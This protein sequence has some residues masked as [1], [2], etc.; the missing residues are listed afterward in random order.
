M[1]PKQIT[2]EERKAILDL[3]RHLGQRPEYWRGDLDDVYRSLKYETQI[4]GVSQD[5]K[6]SFTPQL[7]SIKNSEGLPTS[8]HR[9]VGSALQLK[10]KYGVIYFTGDDV[11]EVYSQIQQRVG[12]FRNKAFRSDLKKILDGEMK[13]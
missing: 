3:C 8:S 2:E 6:I 7:V 1:L 11:D 12:E 4:A 13:K 9:R 10:H 5:F